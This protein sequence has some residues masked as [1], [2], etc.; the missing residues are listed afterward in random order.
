MPGAVFAGFAGS[1][2]LV[3]LAA[4]VLFEDAA[5]LPG[6]ELPAAAPERAV[7]GAPFRARAPLDAGAAAAAEPAAFFLPPAAA[8]SPGSASAASDAPAD[9]L[10]PVGPFAPFAAVAGAAFGSALSGAFV[11]DVPRACRSSAVGA[12]SGVRA[13]PVPD[14]AAF[15]AAP[16]RAPVPGV[17]GEPDVPDVPEVSAAAFAVAAGAAGATA[18]RFP[19]FAP[20]GLSAACP[21]SAA[22]CASEAGGFA[23]ADPV[24]PEVRSVSGAAPGPG[25]DPRGFAGGFGAVRRRPVGRGRPAVSSPLPGMPVPSWLST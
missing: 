8:C 20:A 16:F 24:G 10:V 12:W 15:A 14:G 17:R 9:P 3:G 18:V 25:R 6:P 1:A 23:G 11:P 5:R 7:A 19:G 4:W 2:G 21:W 13:L 22:A